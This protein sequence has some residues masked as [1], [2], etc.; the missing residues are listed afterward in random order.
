MPKQSIIR[1]KKNPLFTV[2]HGTFLQC[3]L[4]SSFSRVSSG[5]H[6]V[7][8]QSPLVHRCTNPVV[9]GRHIIV[10]FGSSNISALSSME[11]LSTKGEKFDYGIP[12]STECFKF[13]HSLYIFQLWVSDYIPS[14][15]GGSFSRDGYV[16]R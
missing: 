10:F 3:D 7:C 13:F 12:F 1:L 15:A 16:T 11:F 9:S 6:C 2:K 8:C 14:S 4:S 5:W